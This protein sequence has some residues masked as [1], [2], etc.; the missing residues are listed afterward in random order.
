MARSSRDRFELTR[1]ALLGDYAERS[2]TSRSAVVAFALRNESTQYLDVSATQCVGSGISWEQLRAILETCLFSGEMPPESYNSFAL[3]ELGRHLL[4]NSEKAKDSELAVYMLESAVSRIPRHAA[5]KR[6]RLLLVQ[7]YILHGQQAAALRALG[8]W[9][10]I[11]LLE[12]GYLTGEAHHPVRTGEPADFD[13]WLSSFNASFRVHGLE[14]IHLE[15]GDRAL[16]DQVS[17]AQPRHQSLVGAYAAGTGPIV[18][19]VV[20]AFQPDMTELLTSVR[21]IL[22][23]TVISLELIL[24]DD[25]SGEQYSEVF[26]AACSLDSRVRLIRSKSN[27]GVYAARNLGYRSA[28]GA[29]VTGQDDDDWSHPQRL[30]AQLSF[31]ENNPQIPG[32]RVMGISCD[33]NLSRVRFGYRSIVKNASSLMVR[34][35]DFIFAGGFSEMRKAADTEFAERIETLFSSEIETMVEPMTLV[36]V[37]TDRLS[38]SEFRLGWSHPARRQVKSAYRHWHAT[39]DRDS[40]RLDPGQPH[41]FHIPR[42]FRNLKASQES[43]CDVIVVNDWR[44][45]GVASRQAVGELHALADSGLNVAVLHMESPDQSY[46]S[47]QAMTPD[48]QALINRGIVDE[49]L[50]DDVVE[51]RTLLVCD[52]TILQFVPDAPS[53]LMVERT[54]V[55]AGISP[56]DG[57][58][59]DL[60]YLPDTCTENARAVFGAEPVWVPRGPAVRSAIESVIVDSQIYEWDIRP[61]VESSEQTS[62]RER[63]QRSGSPVVGRFGSSQTADWPSALQV[64]KG[65]YPIDG[66]L[67]VRVRG[68][69]SPA[70]KTLKSKTV[71][72]AWI[73]HPSDALTRHRFLESLDFYVHFG[74]SSA[75]A[76]TEV[77]EAMAAG[78]VVIAPPEFRRDYGDAAVYASASE[79]TAVTC[80]YHDRR[81]LY[82]VQQVKAAE[83]VSSRFSVSR[84][85]ADTL[86]MLFDGR[87]L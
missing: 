58:G 26:A 53:G 55:F 42:R 87:G 57:D 83:L 65:A 24:V 15:G 2:R 4:L 86:R 85:K 16:F 72:P 32:C 79:L 68:D 54:V 18:S 8:K 25:G 10:D 61:T 5:S 43:Q 82:R 46:A 1:S 35:D 50:Y 59:L 7:Y 9:K 76:S 49:V 70:L 6:F 51:A 33:A 31:L 80:R 38:R 21:S 56:S 77:L 36:R 66:R 67:D 30:R 29:Y 45:N 74:R 39:S 23:Q 78:V 19:V 17:V 69:A 52:P 48:V 81:D 37:G 84:F 44:E 13:V 60:R 64:L 11:R 12:D 73:V 71:P 41:P 47:V 20:A 75:E 40:L 3:A 63:R 22:N 28:R 34:T 14:P 62:V 27:I